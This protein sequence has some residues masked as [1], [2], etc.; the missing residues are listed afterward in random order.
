MFPIRPHRST[1]ILSSAS[2]SAS[3]L[4]RARAAEWEV[5]L[6]ESSESLTMHVWGSELCL[7]PADGMVRIEL[8]A[9][10]Q[11]LIGILQDSATELFEGHGMAIAWDNVDEGALAP[12]LTLMRVESVTQ[13]TP[14]FI[15]VR[16]SGPE[17]IRFGQTNLHFRVLIAPEG[18]QPIWPRIAANGRTRWPEGEDALH[19]PVYTVADQQGDWVEFDIFAHDGSPTCDWA[20]RVQTGEPVG[21]MGP[22][23]GWCPEAKELWLFGDETALPAISRMLD[24]AKGTVRAFVHAA[25][26]DMPGLTDDP[27]VTRCDDLLASLDTA[28]IPVADDVHVWF[29]GHAIQ[30]RE[31]RR[32]LAA[33]GLNKRQFTA[34]AYWGQPD[35]RA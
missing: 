4:L 12:G 26:E 29:A 2:G 11:R 7:I 24:L 23:G 13:R 27:R 32:Q 6:I 15:R 18:R 21:L 9:P 22:G 19:R 16:V 33:R 10:E 34:A 28:A 3:A 8:R 20:R 5:D 35:S 31:A 1:G 17:A 30:A 14:G 25:S